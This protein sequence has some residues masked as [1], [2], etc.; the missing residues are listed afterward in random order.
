MSDP[1]APTNR[2]AGEKS[3]YLLQ[4]ARNPVDWYPWGPEAFERARREDKPV[5]L[6]IGYATCHWCH[7]ME[8]ESFEHAG[9]AAVLN[10]RF[11]AVK[12]DR[13]ERPDVDEIYM[14]AVQAMSGHGGWPMTLF[15]TAEGKPF[16]AGTYFP[17]PGKYGRASFLDLCRSIDGAW[18]EKRGEVLASADAIAAHLG[19]RTGG[20]AGDLPLAPAVLADAAAQLARRFDATHGGFGGGTQFPTPHVLGFLL[21]HHRRAGDAQ[22]LHM[23][24]R[25]LDAIVERGLRD[26]LDGGFHRYC[27]DPAWTIPHFE[28]MLYDQALLVRALVEAWQVTGEPTYAAVAR[29]TCDFVLRRMTAPGG[30]FTSAWDADSEGVEGKCYVWTEAELRAALGADFAPFAL[31]YGVTPEG[32]F[33]ELHGA[34]H[35]QEDMTL[36]EVARRTGLDEPALTATLARARATLLALRERRVQP[37]HDDKVLTDWNGLMIGALAF[38]G[39]ALDEARFVA[40][41]AAAAA[42]VLEALWLPAGDGPPGGRRLLHRLRDGE[43]AI[44]GLL[45]DHAFLA[46]GLLELFEATGE[47]A[48]LARARALAA[49]MRAG[50]EAPEGGFF[51][52]PAAAADGVALLHRPRPV[53]DGAVPAGNSVAALVLGKLALLGQD[54]DLRQAALGA[55]RSAGE[56]LTKAGG[57]GGTQALHAFDLLLGPSREVVVAGDPGDPRTRALLREVDGR[58]LPDAVVVRWPA[59]EGAEG[60]AALTAAL[61]WVAAQGPRGGAPAAYVCQGFACRAPVT[62]AGELRR[63]IGGWR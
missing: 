48:W 1:T 17:M 57:H 46:W 63:E 35:L 21:R 44:E 18:R 10:E 36:A 26:H 60:L 32:N 29:E 33:E 24:R 30:G 53:Y 28:K 5:F 34:N 50:F 4:H 39:R 25:T 40:A 54:D 59:G 2:L 56:L 62:E 9:V 49:A 43:A 45:D 15:L 38:A 23:V 51:Q 55:L 13:E 19:A 14:A 41:A 20:L 27:V 8:R 52:A 16:F 22:A 31:R 58:F 3:P 37:L 61:P 7:V 12:V 47:A 6:S 11:V 42:R